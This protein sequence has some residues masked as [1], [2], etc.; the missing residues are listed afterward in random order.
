MLSMTK[1]SGGNTAEYYCGDNY[2]AA[3][4]NP[5]DSQ[6]LGESAK[7][8]G[9]TGVIDGADFNNAREGRLPDGS[10]A[11]KSEN[12]TPGW[13]LTASAPKSVSILALV[14]KDERLIEAHRNASQKAASFLEGFAAT[15]VRHGQQVRQE[16]TGNLIIGRFTHDTSRAGDPAL[17]DHLF[18]MNRTWHE[19]TKS[20]RSLDS[21]SLFSAKEAA[22][23]LY[24]ATLRDQSQSL[25]YRVTDPDKNGNFEIQGVSQEL[26]KLFSKRRETILEKLSTS[27]QDAT[28]KVTERV[29]LMTRE[30]KDNSLTGSQKSEG[31]RLEAGSRVSVIDTVV[32]RSKMIGARLGVAIGNAV[33]ALPSRTRELTDILSPIDRSAPADRARARAN[34][35]VQFALSHLTENAAVFHEADVV[36]KALQSP[37]AKHVRPDDLLREL[38]HA[39]RQKSLLPAE[40]FATSHYTTR[41]IMRIESA[42]VQASLD[43]SSSWTS[44]R[45]IDLDKAA[46]AQHLSK[47]QAGAFNAALG[48]QQRYAAIVGFPGTGKSYLVRSMKDTLATHAPGAELVTIAPQHRQ[49]AEFREQLGIQADTIAHFIAS[50]L[51]HT[52]STDAAVPDRSNTILVVDEAGQMSNKH[53]RDLTQIAK[54]LNIGRVLFLGDPGQKAAVEQGAPFAAMLDGGIAHATMKDIRRQ[55]TPV[56]RQAAYQSATGRVALSLNTLDPFI[57]ETAPNQLEHD[58]VEHWKTLAPQQRRGALIVTTTNARRATINNLIRDALIRDPRFT[59]QERL[60]EAAHPHTVL[61]SK[62]LSKA[63]LNSATGLEAGDTLIFVRNVRAIGLEKGQHTTLVSLTKD[64]KFALLQKPDGE[65]VKYEFPGSRRAGGHFDA[66]RAGQIELRQNER[67]RWTRSNRDD[68][69]LASTGITVTGITAHSVCLVDETGKQMTLSK[70]DSR[71]R[72]I[73]YNY[74]STSYAGQGLTRET[75]INVTGINDRYAGDQTHANVANTRVGA[76]NMADEHLAIFTDDKAGLKD[77]YAREIPKIDSALVATRRGVLSGLDDKADVARQ[78]AAAGPQPH[79]R[80]QPDRDSVPTV[81]PDDGRARDLTQ[82]LDRAR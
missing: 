53:A 62:R 55:K 6:W 47:D 27:V 8:A 76:K 70:S 25:G 21:R 64:R 75:V 1:D 61:A 5:G 38:A 66:Y 46:R 35:A 39:K 20:W 29:A 3:G 2:Y 82:D 10:Q 44:A 77:R 40:G 16:R 36:S 80:A 33:R 23:R 67:L 54:A 56:L 59:A 51:R 9:L 37:G 14:G 18:I 19:G 48:G 63:E 31:W 17:H 28:R 24:S 43:P 26:Q 71:L 4:D 58:A 81:L 15:R 78:N 74:A 79:D 60:G 12:R 32:A 42:I 68:G 45:E 34:E 41:G 11:K 22:G 52:R 50:N 73:D 30:R 57:R 13:D 49:V 65:T 69:I 7:R 72:H